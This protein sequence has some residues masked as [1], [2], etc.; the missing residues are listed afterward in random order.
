[1]IGFAAVEIEDH[2]RGLQ[3]PRLRQDLLRGLRER[4]LRVHVLGHGANLGSEEEV[5]DSRQHH[6][7]IIPLPAKRSGTELPDHKNGATELTKETQTIGCP[8]PSLP[9]LLRFTDPLPPCPPS[10]AA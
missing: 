4:D 6:P 9:L 8:F 2:Q 10:S 5:V 1:R 7:A 3:R